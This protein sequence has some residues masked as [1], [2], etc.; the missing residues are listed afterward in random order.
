MITQSESFMKKI[1]SLIVLASI[2]FKSCF[3]PSPQAVVLNSDPDT[4]IF[5]VRFDDQVFEKSFNSSFLSSF[6]ATTA[7][8]WATSTCMLS[9]SAKKLF[10]QKNIPSLCAFIPATAAIGL[11]LLHNGLKHKRTH[12][13]Y[14]ENLQ[15]QLQLLNRARKMD[16]EQVL[17]ELKKYARLKDLINRLNGALAGSSLGLLLGVFLG[18]VTANGVDRIL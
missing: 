9:K 6:L 16:H 14:V 4:N 8:S 5:H 18:G 13:K 12:P 2:N 7:G 10:D 3:S 15:D 11:F 1:I 17:R